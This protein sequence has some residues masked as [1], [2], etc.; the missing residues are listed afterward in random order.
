MD[1]IKNKDGMYKLLKSTKTYIK[2]PDLNTIKGREAL[3][4]ILLL[5]EVNDHHNKDKGKQKSYKQSYLRN[6]TG[7]K[8]L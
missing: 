6:I 8:Y 5:R 4:R 3:H 1:C 7:L 2:V